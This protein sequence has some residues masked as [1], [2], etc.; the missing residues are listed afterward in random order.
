MGHEAAAR[1]DGPPCLAGFGV[2]IYDRSPHPD[3]GRIP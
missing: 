3:E 2:E 1:E